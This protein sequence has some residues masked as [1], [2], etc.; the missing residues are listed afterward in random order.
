MTAW[1]L[2]IASSAD[3]DIVAILVWTR[4]HFG[5]RQA[6]IYTRTL[7]KALADLTKGPDVAGVRPR[8]DLAPGILLLPVARHGRRGRHLIVFRLGRKHCLD[9]LRVLHESMDIERHLDH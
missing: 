5:V 3:A 1:T 4:E 2:R 8:D 9:V 6:D 7:A